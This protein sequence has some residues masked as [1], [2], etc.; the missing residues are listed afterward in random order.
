MLATVLRW[1]FALI[2]GTAATV[3]VVLGVGLFTAIGAVL[4]IVSLGT[5]IVVFF[6]VLI[7]EWWENR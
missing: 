1:L 3:V 4:G 6:A 2:L 7:N 5:L